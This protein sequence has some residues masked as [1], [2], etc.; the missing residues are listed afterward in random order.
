MNLQRA[1]I[2]AANPLVRKLRNFATF[3]SDD[4]NAIVRASRDVRR[5]EAHRDIISDGDRPSQ[6][7]LIL[8]GSIA[9]RDDVSMGGRRV[10]RS[11]RMAA[12]SSPP[13]SC[14]ATSATCT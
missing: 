13:T 2:P 14:P 11:S 3:G 10:T 8:D 12:A 1:A 9:V 7:H 6:V 5:I 4:E